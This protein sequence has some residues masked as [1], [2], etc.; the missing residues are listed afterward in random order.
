M[1]FYQEL[2]VC[3]LAADPAAAEALCRRVM[4]ESVAA[5]EARE[6]GANEA[7]EG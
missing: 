6:A 4:A 5:W 2:R 3:A 1:Q 7:M